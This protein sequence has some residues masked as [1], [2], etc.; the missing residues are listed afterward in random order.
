[1]ILPNLSIYFT[2][3]QNNSCQMEILAVGFFHIGNKV[4]E[5]HNLKRIKWAEGGKGEQ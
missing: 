1:V 5:Q 3:C 4:V 2:V